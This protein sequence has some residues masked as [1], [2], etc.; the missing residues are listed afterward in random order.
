MKM[1]RDKRRGSCS[2]THLPGLP[3]PWFPL[4]DLLPKSPHR[5]RKN[6][7][8]SLWKREGQRRILA[9]EVAEKLRLSP[10]PS[11]EGRGSNPGVLGTNCG[12]KGSG[13]G[14]GM[15][16]SEPTCDRDLVDGGLKLRLPSKIAFD[17]DACSPDNKLNFCIIL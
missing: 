3:L 17:I 13:G 1:N 5:V 4:A 12:G 9:S 8:T 16:E 11:E 14:G 10:H 7:P 2:V 15:R 6:R